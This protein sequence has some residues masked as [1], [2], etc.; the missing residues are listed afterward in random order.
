MVRAMKKDFRFKLTDSDREEIR[1]L[2]KMG[3]HN[4]TH[5]GLK[6]GVHPKTIRKVVDEDF[7][8]Y[9]NEFNMENW[10]KYR[11][12]KEHHTELMRVYRKRKKEKNIKKT[13]DT[14]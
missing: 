7:R 14:I 1:K 6:F 12:S 4:Y 3:Y 13:L 2:W 9:C 11:P 5:L 10:Q 8:R